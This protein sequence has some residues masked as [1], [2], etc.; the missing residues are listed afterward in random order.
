M[1]KQNLMMNVLSQKAAKSNW[2]FQTSP[3]HTDTWV[4]SPKDRP[5]PSPDFTTWFSWRGEKIILKKSQC[6]AT[7]FQRKF[8][9]KTHHCRFV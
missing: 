9:I 5:H 7:A 3:D 8:T 6:I 2:P 1:N 4:P